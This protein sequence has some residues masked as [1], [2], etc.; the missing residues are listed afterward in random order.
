MWIGGAVVQLMD[1]PGL[2]G[3]SHELAISGSMQVPRFSTF[4]Q[5][6]DALSLEAGVWFDMESPLPGSDKGQGYEYKIQETFTVEGPSGEFPDGPC[7]YLNPFSGSLPYAWGEPVEDIQVSGLSPGQEVEIIFGDGNPAIIWNRVDEIFG[8]SVPPLA[9]FD[10]IVPAGAPGGDLR[11]FVDGEPTELGAGLHSQFPIPN[12][13]DY[14]DPTNDVWTQAEEDLW[15]FP[16]NVPFW[17]P[18]LA[19]SQQDRIPDPEANPFFTDAYGRGDWWLLPIE[20]D[21]QLCIMVESDQTGN[22][23]FDT[24]LVDNTGNPVPVG[25]YD[26]GYFEWLELDVQAGDEL[27]LWVAP[28][29]IQSDVGWYGIMA[30]ECALWGTPPPTQSAESRENFSV[31]APTT[32]PNGRRLR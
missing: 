5:A 19:F 14:G 30:Q 8:Y 28:R 6:Y 9:H 10:V 20:A 32:L 31:R 16:G 26:G 12:L 2:S 17:G 18:E 27:R 4:C 15:Y 23:D 21:H 3:S 7:T 1:F 13:R 29:S 22:D 11:V 24:V 25:F